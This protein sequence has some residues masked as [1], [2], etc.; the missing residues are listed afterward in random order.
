M[1]LV[2][3]DEVDS[4]LNFLSSNAESI[5]LLHLAPPCGTAS[6]ARGKRLRFLKAHNIKEPRALRDDNHPDGLQWLQGSD[7]LRTEAANLL[8]ETTVLIARAA[9]QHDIAITVENPANSLMWKT[10][11]FVSLFHDFPELKYVTFHNCAHGDSRDKLTC[12][13][14]NVS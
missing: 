12:F 9:I 7:K 3:K 8:Y 10:S 14:T 5:A 13:A 11:P 6:R 2:Y 4:L 1:R